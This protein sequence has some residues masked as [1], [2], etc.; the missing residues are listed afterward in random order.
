MGVPHPGHLHH[1][2]WGPRRSSSHVFMCPTSVRSAGE[3]GPQDEGALLSLAT[4]KSPHNFLRPLGAI[5]S[6]TFSQ[7]PHPPCVSPSSGPEPLPHQLTLPARRSSPS[8][9]LPQECPAVHTACRATW[10]H[11]LLISPLQPAFPGPGPWDQASRWVELLA[12]LVC[13]LVWG[14]LQTTVSGF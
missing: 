5:H 9:G 3:C 12:W 10:G 14:T 2:F 8:A 6:R 13:C 7:S 11:F 4:D 1:L